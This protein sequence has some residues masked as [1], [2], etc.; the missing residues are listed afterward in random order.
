MT[1]PLTAS[2][3]TPTTPTAAAALRPRTFLG[4]FL[5]VW[6]AGV[7]GVAGL[8]APEPPAALLQ[9][10]PQLAG[11][12]AVALR[13]LL[14]VN[15]LLLVTAMA[16]VGAACAHRVGLRSVLAGDAGARVAPGMAVLVG[17]AVALAVQLADAALAPWLGAEWPRAVAAAAAAPWLPALL[18]G[19][20]Y[21][22]IA[23]EI[24]LRWGLM[25]LVIWVLARAFPGRAARGGT[26][27]AALAWT[28][29]VVAAAVF[30]AGHLP[31]LA[32]AVEPTGAIVARTLALNLLAGLA[33]GWLYWRHGLESAMVAHAAS[34]AGFALARLL[35]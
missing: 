2:P 30:A 25:S 29:I 22:G 10:A 3:M 35:P 34:H 1:R 16:A 6:G 19:L 24:L 33:Y 26:P 15:P 27:S 18:Q 17:L 23:E 13:L 28:G 5:P 21:G 12:P 4:R 20:L 32:L 14:L 11:L 8:L 31:A 9:Q 7:V